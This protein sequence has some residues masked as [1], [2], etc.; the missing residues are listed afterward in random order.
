MSRQEKPGL[1]SSEKIIVVNKS[2][3]VIDHR[4]TGHG[5]CSISYGI[6]CSN[7][8]PWIPFRRSGSR[9][10]IYYDTI[11]ISIPRGVMKYAW[12]GFNTL[13]TENLTANPFS[14]AKIS[15]EAYTCGKISML[16]TGT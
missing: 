16:Q 2:L 9:T 14:F 12:H 8:V 7:S 3:E 6:K 11:S 13:K 15:H 5:A 4:T 10:T 1:M